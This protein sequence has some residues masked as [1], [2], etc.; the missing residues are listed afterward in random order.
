MS[1]FSFK[2]PDLGEGSV[3]SEISEWHIAVG[4]YVLEDQVIADVQTDKAIVEVG[5]PVSGVVVALGCN[6]GDML[7]VG[8]ELVRFATESSRDKASY[9]SAEPA[10]T[11]EATRKLS[12]PAR[13]KET[14]LSINS[15][16]AN[17]TTESAAHRQSAQ[18]E[19]RATEAFLETGTAAP[20]LQPA[21]NTS[22]VS[23]VLASPSLRRRAREQGVNLA[24]V[25]STHPSGRLS[26]EDLDSFLASQAS[27]TDATSSRSPSFAASLADAKPGAI[28]DQITDVPLNGTRRVIAKKLQAAKRN[29]PHYSY[30]EEVDV[31]ELESTRQFLNEERR[32]DQ[33]KLT[34]LPFILR[35]LVRSLPEFPHCNARYDEEAE[36]LQQHSAVH[37]G[38]ATMTPQGLKVPVLQNAQAL[39]VWQCAEQIAELAERA[40][41]NRCRPAEL[42]GSTITVTS[43]GSLGGIASTPVIN[44]PET[45]IIGIN[46]MQRRPVVLGDQIVPR[47]MM[48]LS[49]SFDHRIVDGFDGARLVQALCK[50]LEHPSSLFV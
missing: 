19:Q 16:T 37:A 3:E 27:T 22:A 39:D 32:A 26:H 24:L 36:L 5:S 42:T 38:I 2:L 13:P 14:V 43:L 44:A 41:S 7:P 21:G 49:A 6:A 10:P 45:A 48:N 4:E 25:P 28:E 47:L 23:E 11:D 46:K 35:A 50:R 17:S 20:A 8:A 40:R 9:P 29:I 15:T 18:Q 1:E 12:N 34:L 31:T 30:V 33:T